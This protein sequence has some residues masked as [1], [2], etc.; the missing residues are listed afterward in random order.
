VFLRGEGVEKGPY[1]S[2]IGVVAVVLNDCEILH[3]SRSRSM[4]IGRG[5][6][7]GIGGSR[8]DWL[9]LSISLSRNEG[10]PTRRFGG[11]II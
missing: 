9:P 1:G 11:V 5:W 3:Y 6:D 7:L 10:R 2:L 8:T 4:S